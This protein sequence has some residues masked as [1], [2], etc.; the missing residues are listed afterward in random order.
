MDY[1][2]LNTLVT[3]GFFLI[4]G[5]LIGWLSNPFNKAKFYRLFGRH[6]FVLFAMNKNG[7]ARPFLVDLPVG[8]ELIKVKVKGGFNKIL[9]EL[10]FVPNPKFNGSWLTIPFGIFDATDGRQL[11]LEQYANF[12]GVE[13]VKN[14][15]GEV[16]GRRE[17]WRNNMDVLGYLMP[18]S[19]IQNIVSTNASANRI[20]ARNETS[21]DGNQKLLLLIAAAC[22]L[23][24]LFV[25]VYVVIQLPAI[26]N[27][28]QSAANAAVVA[29]N[30]TIV[31][32]SV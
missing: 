22:S 8:E 26:A 16:V 31:Y 28:A 6:K 7:F 1:A 32:K 13:E 11:P 20:K 3:V 19:K 5:F 15:R 21:A 29:A 27:A 17:V 25:T 23:I 18:P 4:V 9:Q 2:T 12:L 10:T 30:Q 24:G 14:E